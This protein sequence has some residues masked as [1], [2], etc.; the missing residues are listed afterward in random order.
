VSR[1]EGLGSLR[2]LAGDVDVRAA[3]WVVAGVRDFA[4]HTI[5]SLVP[6]LFEAYARVLHPAARKDVEVS[7]AQVAAANGRQAHSS[8]E[9]VGITGSWAFLHGQVQP[10]VWDTEPDEGSLPAASA[11]VLATVLA[12]FTS[13]ADDCFYAVWDGFGASAL[14]DATAAR[15]Q[16]PQRPMLLA[17]GPLSQAARV[18]MEAP[19]WDQS[20]SLW[21]PA[22]R[23]WCVATD[24]DLMSTYVGGSRACIDAVLAAPGLEVWE[25]PDSQRVSFDSDTLNPVPPPPV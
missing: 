17:T 21:W 20:P 24:V 13:T 19:P 18:S 11:E 8:M 25:V 10:E 14:D 16:M 12:G 1:R 4:G 22:D 7:W 2:Q 6:P 23:A 3:D 9:W 5:G 15:V